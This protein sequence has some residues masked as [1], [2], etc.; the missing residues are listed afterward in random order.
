MQ[1]AV[2]D[3]CI[4]IDLL[5]LEITSS[6]FR[7]DLEIHTTVEVINELYSEQQEVLLAYQTVKKLTVHN[8]DAHDL[9]L[10]RST[11][12]PKALSHQDKSVIYLA[13]QLNAIVL[14]SDGVVRKFAKK[15]AIETHG[16][17]WIFDQLVLQ[18]LLTQN[19]AM[20][21]LRQFMDGNLMYRNNVLLQREAIKR[22]DRWSQA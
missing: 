3:A 14:S 1:I 21:K 6:F 20:R 13:A 16:I 22:I 7:L 18:E 17:F 19:D 9:Q 8:L 2:T 4:F 5:E 11:S 15:I 10:L 12:F